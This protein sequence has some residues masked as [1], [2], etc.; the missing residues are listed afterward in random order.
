MLAKAPFEFGHWGILTDR[1]EFFQ[2]LLGRHRTQERTTDL[3]CESVIGRISVMCLGGEAVVAR[4]LVQ[5][6]S[7]GRKFG[8]DGFGDGFVSTVNERLVE[9]RE[10]W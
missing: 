8:M 1:K 10:C 6:G 2:E 5:Y 9:E 3:L 7:T 4:C